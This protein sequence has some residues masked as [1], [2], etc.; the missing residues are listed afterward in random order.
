[1]I[2]LKTGNIFTTQCAFIVNTVNCVGAMGAGIAYEYYWRFPEMNERYQKLCAEK[3]LDIGILWIYKIPNSNDGFH[4][5]LN[6][7]TKKHWKYPS[8]EEYLKKGLEKFIQIYQEENIQSIAFPYLGSGKGGLS[9]E[10]SL[11]IMKQ[12]L[13]NLPIKI[14]IWTFDP[15]AEDD[16]YL[17]FKNKFLS[18]T[19]EEIRKISGLNHRQISIIKNYLPAVKNMSGLANIKGI[20]KNSLEKLRKMVEIK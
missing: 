5:I 14:E 19:D 4:S 1:M 12:Y 10:T 18:Q 13:E 16:F 15:N 3:Q 2:E 17:N 20:G 11:E 7:P 9:S 6:F 8:K